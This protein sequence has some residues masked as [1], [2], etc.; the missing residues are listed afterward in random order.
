MQKLI[1]RLREVARAGDTITYRELGE[2]V[3]LDVGT[4]AERTQLSRILTDVAR[5]EH[6]AGRPLLT[7]VVVDENGTAG[8][9]FYSVAS[10][11]GFPVGSYDVPFFQTELARVH[12]YWQNEG[13]E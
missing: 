10:E 11:L 12:E 5:H 1:E 3:G 8:Y 2:D 4:L 9:E 13:A 7:A 6:E